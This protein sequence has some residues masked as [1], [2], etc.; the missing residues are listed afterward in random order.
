MIAEAWDCDGLNQVREEVWDGVCVGGGLHHPLNYPPCRCCR[1]V[2]SH[3]FLSCPL[4]QV[5]AFPHFGGRWSEWNG[6]F[7]DVVR[8]FI[9]VWGAGEGSLGMCGGEGRRKCGRQRRMFA[10]GGACVDA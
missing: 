8:N 5:G 2:H 6:R 7:R 9:K 1:S 4:L 10:K 3:T